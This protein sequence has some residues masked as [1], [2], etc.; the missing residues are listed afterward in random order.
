MKRWCSDYLICAPVKFQLSSKRFDPMTCTMPVQSSQHLSHGATQMRVGQFVWLTCSR[1]RNSEWKKFYD[2]WLRDEWSW[3]RIPL[4]IPE[5]FQV[6]IRENHRHCPASVTI[7]SSKDMFRVDNVPVCG[8]QGWRS[9][10]STRLPP[11][12]SWFD[13]QIRRHVGWVC[14]FSSLLFSSL[15]FSSLHREVF[16]G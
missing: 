10:E 11:I 12:R 1:E 3:I 2:V 4:K 13:S 9:G 8:V 16:S 5:V 15:L 14:W 6:H 7:I